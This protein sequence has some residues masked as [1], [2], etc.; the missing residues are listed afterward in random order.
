[1][2]DD[3]WGFPTNRREFLTGLGGGFAGLALTS[4]LANDSL[5]ADPA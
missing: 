4:L 3:H 2:S 5:A 1:M